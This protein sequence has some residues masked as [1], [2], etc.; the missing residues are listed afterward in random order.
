MYFEIEKPSKE[1]C[2]LCFQLGDLAGNIL[3]HSEVFRLEELKLSFQNQFIKLK[4]QT[5]IPGTSSFNE[6]IFRHGLFT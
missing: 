3:K 4:W 2:V 6:T 5:V 1:I